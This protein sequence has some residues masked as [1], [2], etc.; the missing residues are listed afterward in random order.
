M[1][2]RSIVKQGGTR[3]RV[4]VVISER[5]IVHDTR[6][7]QNVLRPAGTIQRRSF[8][9]YSSLCALAVVVLCRYDTGALGGACQACKMLGDYEPMICTYSENVP[10][11]S[12]NSYVR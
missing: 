10:Y 7:E 2:S 9:S 11:I 12:S 1:L 8:A 6:W 5:R 4:R 3:A